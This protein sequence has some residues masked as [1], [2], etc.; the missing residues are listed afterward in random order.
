M[1]LN[2]NYKKK[3]KGANHRTKESFVSASNKALVGT[4]ISIGDVI[5]IFAKQLNL[6]LS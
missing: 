4:L 1:V 3:K 2:K 6:L 5:D